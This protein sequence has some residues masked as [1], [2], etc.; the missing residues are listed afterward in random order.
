MTIVATDSISAY[1]QDAVE[2]A[3]KARHVE[4]TDMATHYIV[5]L[6]SDYARPD[7]N[8]GRTLERPLT[9]LLDEA[10]HTNAPAE[11]F[12]RLRTLGDGVLYSLGFFRD[13]FE[14]KGVE[15]SYLVGIGSVAYG[16]ASSVLRSSVQDVEKKLD[17]YRELADKFA[18][19]V[20][21][22]GE[23]AD[24]TIAGSVAGSRDLLKVYERWL[25]TG[26]GRL[27]ET[28]TSHGLVPMRGTKGTL[29]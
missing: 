19:F 20:E 7:P 25:K 5:A 12:D 29:Q 15:Q 1:F 13:H 22:L 16:G 11:R 14:S 3:M 4:A 23:I 18:S 26:S 27:A 24:S 10:L 6:L 21:V 17:I 8:V 2:D 9:F 28:L